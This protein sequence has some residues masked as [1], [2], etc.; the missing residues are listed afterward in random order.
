MSGA[1]H[2]SGRAAP[3]A[4]SIRQAPALHAQADT[5]PYAVPIPVVCLL[6]AALACAPSG[7]EPAPAPASDAT[8]DATADGPPVRPAN[9]IQVVGV[10]TNLYGYTVEGASV[11]VRVG[12]PRAV[13]AAPDVECDG[14][15]NWPAPTRTGPT[16]RFTVPVRA[17]VGPRFQACLEVEAL[18]PPRARL[19]ERTVVVPAVVFSPPGPDGAPAD[20]VP[21]HIALY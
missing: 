15:S 21:V 3:P 12:E 16:G 18:P 10:V 14:A 17:G 4:P 5:M 13:G 11:T 8:G 9:A 6:L 19:Q 2:A 20:T 7:S 1:D